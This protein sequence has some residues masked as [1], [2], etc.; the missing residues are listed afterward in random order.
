[1]QL[2]PKIT[3]QEWDYFQ[4]GFSLRTLKANEFFFEAG[5]RNHQLGFVTT[6]LVRGYYINQLGED[7]T[8][9]FVPERQWVTDYPSLLM[10]CPS[11]YNFQCL[12][13][14]IIVS[15]SYAHICNGYDRFIGFERN[16]RLIA[17]EVLKAQ[18]RRIE[19]FQFD[20]AEQ[21]YQD[22]VKDNPGIFN[23][24]SLTKL[25]S[26]LGIKRPSLSRIR[27]KIFGQ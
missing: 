3:D 13:P 14:T 17:E 7:I 9:V 12:E 18:Q 11:R 19:S 20:S 8:T 25:S 4:S 10:S 6:G 26:Y 21:R 1:M 5:K 24:I 23:R 27:K 22:F 2:N 16:G 15:I